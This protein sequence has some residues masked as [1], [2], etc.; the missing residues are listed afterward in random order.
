MHGD[1]EYL[2]EKNGLC[3]GIINCGE[4]PKKPRDYFTGRIEKLD[5][6]KGTW[7]TICENISGTYMGYMD[8]DSERL[9]DIRSLEED[10][11][12]LPLPLES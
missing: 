5:R 1:F 11:E 8:F 3:G 4:V 2:D 10:L 7:H 9:F 6:E 12:Q